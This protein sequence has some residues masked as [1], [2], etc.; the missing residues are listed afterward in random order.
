MKN[1]LLLSGI[2]IF[3]ATAYTCDFGNCRTKAAFSNYSSPSSLAVFKKPKMLTLKIT[4]IDCAG[5]ASGIHTA[6]LKTNG[7]LSDEI[8]FP[9][10]LAVIRYDPT[11][12][13]GEEIVALIERLGFKASVIKS[14]TARKAG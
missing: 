8:K 3:F 1:V 12:I 7:I 4:G 14:K 2:I 11:K 13:S 6:L 9:G 10:D 5:C